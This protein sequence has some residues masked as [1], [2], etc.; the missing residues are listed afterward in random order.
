[1]A[2]KLRQKEIYSIDPRRSAPYDGSLSLAGHEAAKALKPDRRRAVETRRRQ[3]RQ[4][5]QGIIRFVTRCPNLTLTCHWSQIE[6]MTKINKKEAG[7]CPYSKQCETEIKALEMFQIT[8]T[9]FTH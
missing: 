6:K 2:V 8:W 7:F 9:I 3:T 1:M 5:H 4:C